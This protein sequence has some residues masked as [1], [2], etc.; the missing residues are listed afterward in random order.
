MTLLCS[1]H[2]IYNT[3]KTLSCLQMEKKIDLLLEEMMSIKREVKK[4]DV[5]EQ[6]VQNEFTSIHKKID[7]L[8]Q[9]SISVNKLTEEMNDTKVKLQSAN[10]KIKTLKSEVETLQRAKAS[11]QI[12][13]DNL[14]HR[15]KED[16]ATLIKNILAALQ[17]PTDGAFPIDAYRLGQYNPTKTR[18]P[19]LL[20]EFSSTHIRD[21]VMTYWRMKKI[22]LSEEICPEKK[23]FGIPESEERHKIYIN[24]NY[25][26][27]IRALLKEARKLKKHGFKSVYEFANSVYVKRSINDEPIKIKDSEFIQQLINE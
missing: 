19:P 27:S 7:D 12:I 10:L 9:I 1:S 23:N 15:P 3:L 8:Q 14:P 21:S 16:L 4:I 25:S 5:L 6:K 22:L 24:K 17:C 18:P 11:R 20:L 2:T 26:P 13:V